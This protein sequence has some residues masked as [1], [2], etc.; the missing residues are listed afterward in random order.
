[1][2]EEYKEGKMEVEV[3]KLLE[4]YGIPYAPDNFSVNGYCIKS[5]N[6]MLRSIFNEIYYLT[7]T[8]DVSPSNLKEYKNT[9]E[10]GLN[11][12]K[13]I[14]KCILVFLVLLRTS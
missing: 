6:N 13:S 7:Y 10:K 11:I 1:M 3:K 5:I 4:Y 12:L 14:I 8:V 2:G 9:P